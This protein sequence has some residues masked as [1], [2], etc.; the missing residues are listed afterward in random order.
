L[1]FLHESLNLRG[2]TNIRLKRYRHTAGGADTLANFFSFRAVVKVIHCDPNRNRA[3]FRCDSRAETA[4][5][6]RDQC[7][8][9]L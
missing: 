9:I 1:N 8:S 5:P 6:T 4:R 7:R 2:L 3:E